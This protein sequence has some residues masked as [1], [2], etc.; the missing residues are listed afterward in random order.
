MLPG[1]L[2]C[3][4]ISAPPDSIP[5]VQ[6]ASEAHKDAVARFG[7]AVWNLRRDRLLTAAKQLEEAAKK[8]GDATAPLRELI[9][10]YTLLGR[11]PDAIRIAK[12]ILEKDPHD[13][14]I[15]HALV[16]LLFDAGEL[17]AAIAIAKLAAKSP[18]PIDRADKAVAVYR[19]LATLCEK[20]NDPATAAMT[21]RKAIEL[22]VDQRKEVI[23]SRAFTPREADTAAAECLERLG[24]VLTKLQ[25]WDEA[26]T[27]FDAA[28]QLFGDPL[29]ANDPSAAARLDWNLSG[30]LQHK[31]D[32]RT[33]LEHLEKVLKHQPVS[34]EPYLRLAQ[35]LRE[36]GRETEI[37]AKLKGYD[38]SLKKY[39]FIQAER[40]ALN[41][42]LAVELARSPDESNGN[43]ADELIAKIQSTTNDP[44]L[45]AIIVRCRVELGQAR[46]IVAELDREFAKIHDD[47]KEEKAND[48]SDQA[49][50]FAAEKAR[51]LADMLHGDANATDA[52]LAAAKKD[53]QLGTKRSHHTCYFLGQLAAYHRK[54]VIAELLFDPL[55]RAGPEETRGEA[56]LATIQVLRLAGKPNKLV[57]VCEDGLRNAKSIA[58]FILHYYLADAYVSLGKTQ[59]AIE[60]ADKAIQD[61]GH[62]NRLMVRLHKVSVLT[63]L[64]KWD[65][66]ID[67]AKKLF[68][69]YPAPADR[70][71]TRY[72]LATAYWAAG[73][74][75]EAET[76]LRTI[77]EN[78]PDHAAAS[79]D[80]GFHLADQG[81]ELDYAEQ[82]IRN[83]IA[84]DKFDRR[85]SG[86]AERE[87]AAY[88]DSLG[89]VLFRMGKLAEAR[90][91]LERASLLHEGE[92]DP[93]VWDHLGDVLFR[94]GEKAEAKTAWERALKIYNNEGHASS[95]RSED[96]YNEIERK[97]KRVP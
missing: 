57:E 2:L 13:I 89:W 53:L 18:I 95:R 77:L 91:E 28:A 64:E 93:I 37:I 84:I 19:D 85:K 94:L 8:D 67:L 16:G 65:D 78:D 52:V 14:D 41:T 40:I 42:V 44:K 3:L 86:A 76:E 96:R 22:V 82:L 10:V 69:D 15:A 62:N 63:R 87:S 17:K 48:E 50:A 25:K 35:L 75:T 46:K 68:E 21:L 6:G 33:A 39:D 4:A 51:V 80:L 49:K 97:L 60:E 27:A 47:A 70:L 26:S 29:K 45:I 56:Y 90:T 59:L 20:A 9:R 7:T 5:F 24:K 73:K 12:R 79:N 30:V 74:N 36:L 34:P 54:L 23:A 72:Q 71:Q 1:L 88:I 55:R 61:T 38:L 11:E 58:P 83:A 81:R 32:A 43:R 66:A 31:G 92:I